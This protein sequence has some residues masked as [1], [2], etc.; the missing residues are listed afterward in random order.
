MTT[1]PNMLKEAVSSAALKTK[2][3]KLTDGQ[4]VDVQIGSKWYEVIFSHRMYSVYTGSDKPVDY[5]KADDV[6]DFLTTQ[7]PIKKMD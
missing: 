6:W 3:N 5:K 7:G 2:L 4:G 1:F